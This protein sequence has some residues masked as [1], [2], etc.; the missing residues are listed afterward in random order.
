MNSDL[1]QS[2]TDRIVASLEQGGA[3]VDAAVERGA[4]GGTHHPAFAGER[5]LSGDQCPRVVER[6]NRPEQ[7]NPRR[8][9][10]IRACWLSLAG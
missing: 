5:R 3:T 7:K 4:R 9:R 1:Y 8:S 10:S 6:G 2:V